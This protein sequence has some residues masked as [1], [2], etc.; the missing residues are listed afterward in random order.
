MKW[1]TVLLSL[2]FGSSVLAQQ[3]TVGTWNIEWLGTPHRRNGGARTDAQLED[4]AARLADELDIEVAVLVEINTQSPQWAT[5][6]SRLE[7]RG[8]GF[9]EGSGG[10]LR[11]VI[12]FDQDEVQLSGSFEADLQTEFERPGQNCF[13]RGRRPLLATLRAGNFDFTVIGVHL[14]SGFVPEGCR[15]DSFPE[16]VRTQQAQ[17]IVGE[18]QRG[19]TER[20]IDSD[21]IVVGDFNGGMQDGGLEAFRQAGY[22][23]LSEE[24][25]RSDASGSLTYRKGRFRS[26]LDHLAVPASTIREWVALSTVFWAPLTTMSD[27]DLAAYLRAFSDHAPVWTHFNTALADDD[28]LAQ[29]PAPTVVLE[30]RCRCFCAENEVFVRIAIE[31]CREANGY[32]CEI[33]NGD[34]VTQ[35]RLAQ[36]EP[37]ATN[38]GN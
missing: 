4:I 15:D 36:C 13:T 19:W 16:W 21:V 5:L 6:R 7:Q 24:R 1:K 35:G 31:M 23:I 3:V 17:Q 8:Y 34:Q 29:A 33:S 27:D 9:V 28:G 10:D 2:V 11:I 26:V 25:R 14:K 37:V 22:S 18:I 30:P 38:R 12:A 20:L 32:S